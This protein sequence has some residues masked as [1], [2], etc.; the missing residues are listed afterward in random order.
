MHTPEEKLGQ[1]GRSPEAVDQVI[2]T[3]TI[4]DEEFFPDGG[5]RAWLVVAGCFLISAVV[6]GFW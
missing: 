5:L 6:V 4:E 3:P 1:K 2:S